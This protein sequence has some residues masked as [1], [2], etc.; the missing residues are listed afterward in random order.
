MPKDKYNDLDSLL[1]AAEL[2]QTKMLRLQ[3]DLSKEL[4]EKVIEYYP[5]INSENHSTTK[6]QDLITK[7][8]VQ[9]THEVQDLTNGL[10]KDT[11]FSRK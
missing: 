6:L 1:N 10:Y 8:T 3:D 4:Y 11:C 7:L 5:E 9:F 2:I